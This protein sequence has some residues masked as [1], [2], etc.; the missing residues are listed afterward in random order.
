GQQLADV[1]FRNHRLNNGGQD[2]SEAQRPQDFPGHDAGHLQSHQYVL[3][4]FRLC[5]LWMLTTQRFGTLSSI[6]T[7]SLFHPYT[8]SRPGDIR[9]HPRTLSLTPRAA[10]VAWRNH[11]IVR[12]SA[13]R[14]YVCMLSTRSHYRKTSQR[15]EKAHHHLL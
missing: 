2:E 15:G 1:F 11:C 5:L 9:E 8:L 14:P 7:Q 4:H 12:F 3:Q 10:L 13:R 6:K